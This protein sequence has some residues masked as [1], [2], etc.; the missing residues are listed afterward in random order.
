MM[1]DQTTFT[2]SMHHM[3]LVAL[4]Y[5]LS[6][7]V[8]FLGILAL[9]ALKRRENNET[10]SRFSIWLTR[11]TLWGMHSQMDVALY[12]GV[13]ADLDRQKAALKGEKAE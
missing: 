10:S 7:L 9:R 1:Q 2:T 4:P 12:N 5:A 6:A 3:T 11:L 13:R 8:I